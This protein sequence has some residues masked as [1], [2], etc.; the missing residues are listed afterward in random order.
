MDWVKNEY[1]FYLIIPI[2]VQERNGN[3]LVTKMKS[4]NE[5]VYKS[6]FCQIKES[7][8]PL[9]WSWVLKR[10]SSA[11]VSPESIHTVDGLG[12]GLWKWARWRSSPTVSEERI[13]NFLLAKKKKWSPRKYGF[14]PIRFSNG[15]ANYA[16]LRKH[17]LDIRHPVTR[18][19]TPSPPL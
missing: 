6:V 4:V 2:F 9:G 11:T 3:E 19:C 15:G 7:I 1:C 14:L 8:L 5:F 12:Q 17:E 10:H 18:G 13:W 16:Y